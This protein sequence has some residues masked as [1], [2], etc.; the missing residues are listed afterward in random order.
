M[1]Y[2]DLRD[3]LQLLEKKRLLHKIKVDVDPILEISEITDRMSKSLNG[4]KAL[5][6]EKVKGSSIPVVTNIFGSFDR[7]C[8]ALEVERLD[9]VGK[10]IEKLFNQSP[11]KSFKEKIKTFFELIEISK[12]LP[13]KVKDA[14]CQEVID[15][16]P[17]LSKLPIL[18][19][20]PLDGGRF[21]TLPMVFTR[22]PETGKQ[23]CGMYRMHVYD[24]KT[25]GMHW[26]IHKDSAMHYRKYK[27]LGKI[28]P[29][30]VAIGS[31]PA[32]IYS[33]TAP[34][35]YGVDEMIFAGFLRKNSVEMV[36]C[37]TSDIEVPAN[38]EIVLEGY[39]DPQELRDEGPF[40]DHTGFYSPVDKFPVFHVVCITHRKNPVYPATVVGKPPME[41]CYMG[42]ATERIFLPLLRMQ[43]PEIIDMNL[44]MEGVFHNA[45]IISIRKQYPGHGK[46]IIH[47]LW[48]MGQMMFSKLIIVVDEDVDVQDLSTTAWKVLNNVDWRRDVIIAE[49]PVDELDHSSS[50]P[51][52]GGKMGIDATRKT[53]EEGMMRDWPEE[54]KQDENIK[55]LVTKRWHEYGF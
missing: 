51:R 31:D 19:T 53:R 26:H 30:S 23:N 35:P 52:F 14:P 20:W 5:Y 18:K 9:D 2:S 44:P 28:M 47:G 39:I 33:A 4:G 45:A 8:L 49:G 34:L 16:K 55:E 54:I 50:M 6:F 48:G 43:F 3:F 24:E 12:Y 41:D 7:M 40:G 46:K 27:E 17:D 10:R 29:V 15:N 38:A 1:P 13:K 21:I 37:I 22:D 25:T 42:K 36:K 32:V 11:P